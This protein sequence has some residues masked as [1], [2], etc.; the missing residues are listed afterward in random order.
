MLTG[1]AIAAGWADTMITVKNT[2]VELEPHGEMTLRRSVSGPSA[3]ESMLRDRLLDDKG[4][5]DEDHD[6]PKHQED[7]EE[8]DNHERHEEYTE[9]ESHQE[10]EKQKK[11]QDVE[12]DEEG[13]DE[14][15]DEEEEEDEEDGKEKKRKQQA[16]RIRRQ[17]QQAQKYNQDE[18]HPKVHAVT[19]QSPMSRYFEGSRHTAPSSVPCNK[20]GQSPMSR[21]FDGSPHTAP[22]SKPSNKFAMGTSESYSGSGFQTQDGKNASA[23]A[24][25]H[26][27]CSP[28]VP[29]P[30]QPPLMV[31]LPMPCLWPPMPTNANEMSLSS[32]AHGWPSQRNIVKTVTND[33]RAYSEGPKAMFV[34]L[35]K[36]KSN[37][38]SAKEASL[39]Q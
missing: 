20:F 4:E 10:D 31:L 38:A 1:L 12:D 23:M 15:E 17:E 2:F 16:P 3:M 18:S 32:A 35:S 19:G 26:G 39:R 7:Y 14:D 28:L 30:P 5:Q 34:D 24:F 21:Y 13:E 25:S 36:L 29:Q 22:S 37:C 11:L 9:H 8:Q 33:W 27:P 6:E